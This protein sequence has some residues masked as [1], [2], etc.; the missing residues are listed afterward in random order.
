MLEI[1]EEFKKLIPPL[2]VEEFKQLEQNCLD[3]GIR[4]KIITWN[5]FIID[6]HNRYEIATRW[7]LEYKTESKYFKSENDVKI[8]MAQNQL[9]RR[10]L[11]DYVMGELYDIIE[12]LEKQKGKQIQLQT[13]KQGIADPV[14]STIDNTEKHNTRKI[15][16]EK[17][18][19]ST[20]KK[21]QFDVVKKKAPEEIKAQLR[22]GEISINQAYKEIKKEE[23]KAE[24]KEKVLEARIE[25]KINESIK[26]GNSL[27]IL[28]TLED[29][30]ID[31]VLTDPPYG[32]D[33]VSNRSTDENAITKR[34]LL[35]D[36]KDEAFDLLEKTCEIL[37]RKTA[38]NS[39]LYFFCSWS[40]FSKFE[41]IISKYF[42]IKTPIIW[43][44]GNK[45]SGDLDN[46]WGNQTEI[47]IYCVKGKKLINNRR[48]N[49]ISVSRLHTSKM[50]HP[51]QKPNELIK[52]IL[53]VSFNEGDFIVD[54]FMGSGSTIK[55]CKELKA[56]CLGIEL[57]E[58]MFN[59]ANNYI[60]GN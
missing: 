8:W 12:Q 17:L 21:A 25:T 30:C 27:E 1:K 22:T 15:I 44:K 34:G 31:I 51:T 35:N 45:G 24:Y 16:S 37:Q 28:E 52:E 54:P 55:V 41:A 60:N 43:D 3:E 48:G 18:G 33:Y 39:H 59:I 47:I 23:K 56:K 4:E 38:V 40:V 19:W 2:T 29:G 46:D 13:L 9:G 10:N 49:L 14:L 20:G 11:A 42:T 58:E 32:I 53:E 57:D 7:N 36:G 5:G 50:I 6:G 26:Q